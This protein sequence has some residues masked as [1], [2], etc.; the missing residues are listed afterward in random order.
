MAGPAAAQPALTPTVDPVF[1]NYLARLGDSHLVLGHRLSEWCGH[2]PVLE[3][4]IALTNLA[5]DCLGHAAVLLRMVGQADGTGRDEDQ[6][7]Y[8]REAV[9]YRNLLLTEQANGDFAHTIARV[10]LFAAYTHPLYEQLQRDR[11]ST[12]LNSSH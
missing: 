8:F 12:R 5:L 1:A 3:E 7:A 10:F 2:G 6:L 9:E 11:K 4:D